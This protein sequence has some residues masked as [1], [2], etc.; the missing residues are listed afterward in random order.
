MQLVLAV[1]QWRSKTIAQQKTWECVRLRNS[2]STR[3]ELCPVSHSLFTLDQ[4]F[5]LG[6]TQNYGLLNI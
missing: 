2:L 6:A 1:S 4:A 3:P 5:Y